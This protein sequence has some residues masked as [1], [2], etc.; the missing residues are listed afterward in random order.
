MSKIEQ[1][2][3]I[4]L[5]KKQA[6]FEKQMMQQEIGTDKMNQQDQKAA[7]KAIRDMINQEHSERNSQSQEVRD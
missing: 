5:E 2:F 7:Q 6:L 1:I 4:E 3:E